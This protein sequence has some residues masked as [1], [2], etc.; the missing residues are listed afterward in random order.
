MVS[1]TIFAITTIVLLI[2]AVSGFALYAFNLSQNGSVQ[3]QITSLQSQVNSLNTQLSLA[4]GQIA[5]LQQDI[6]AAKMARTPGFYNGE[7][8]TFFYPY[9]FNCTPSLSTYFPQQSSISSLTNCEVGAG[10][11]TAEQGAVPL[12]ILVPAYAGLSIFGVQALGATSLG[13]PTFQ[14]QTIITQCGASGTPSACPDHPLLLYS[15]FFAAVEK[16]LGID[17]GYGGLPEGV[18]PTPAHDHLINCC[19]K[20]VPW[21]S[22][23]VL[24]F[25]PN[26]MPNAVTGTCTQV[27]PSN[28]TDPTGNCLSSFQNLENALNT[29]SSAVISAN[30]NNPIWST[31][32]NPSN[33]VII[34]GV[35]TVAQISNTNSNLF[36]HF[37]VN[38]TNPYLWNSTPP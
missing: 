9:N 18:L 5:S 12:W 36:E 29:H 11:A 27:V 1:N 2:L 31:L 30:Q 7:V 35:A 14:N 8:V 19:L 26:I 25:D 34:P 21:Y 15:P 24:V 17:N 10:N 37:T 4:K 22:I 3:Q 13:F 20:V 38:E 6:I 32:N 28:L 16:N 23:V 33:Q